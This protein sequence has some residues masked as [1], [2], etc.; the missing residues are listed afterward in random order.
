MKTVVCEFPLFIL[1]IVAFLVQQELDL[2]SHAEKDEAADTENS[3]SCAFLPL[4]MFLRV[5]LRSIARSSPDVVEL[6][7]FMKFK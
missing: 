1:S 4:E 3:R 6:T 7:M 5:D 2:Q